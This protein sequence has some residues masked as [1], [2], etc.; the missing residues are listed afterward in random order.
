MD[1]EWAGWRRRYFVGALL[2]DPDPPFAV[3]AITPKP[4]LYGSEIDG[5]SGTERGQCVSYKP[6]VVFPGGAV[7]HDGRFLLSVG[8]NDSAC[9]ILKITP[10]QLNFK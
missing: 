6:R 3:V 7:E 9:A 8:L 1:N 4:L 5:L 2:M 10:E